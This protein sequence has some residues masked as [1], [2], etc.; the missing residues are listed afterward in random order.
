MLIDLDPN[1][2]QLL[3]AGGLTLLGVIITAVIWTWAKVRTVMFWF[4]LSLLPIALY[5]LGL[6]PQVVDA[7]H[8]L[9]AWYATLSL[10][11]LVWTGISL[12]GLGVALMLISRFVPARPRRKAGAVGSGAPPRPTAQR[13]AAVAAPARPAPAASSTRTTASQATP[14]DDLD[15]VTEILRRRGIE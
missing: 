6:G 7:Y 11:P 4:G 8:T 13:P 5:L 14:S 12:G 3:V 9:R 1:L 2:L 15:E 10:T